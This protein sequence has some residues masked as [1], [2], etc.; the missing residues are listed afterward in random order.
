M[1]EKSSAYGEKQFGLHE[2]KFVSMDGLTVVDLPNS[3]TLAFE[4]RVISAE[5]PGDDAIQALQ[6][7]PIAADWELEHGGIPLA[8][9]ALVTGRTLSVDGVS[10]NESATLAGSLGPFPYFQIFGKVLDESTGDLHCKLGKAKL[11]EAPKGKF[12]YGKFVVLSMKGTA[13]KDAGGNVY[14]FA[15]HETA[16][17]LD[18]PSSGS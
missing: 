9:Y 4:E 11:T 12:E 3:Q 13:L 10:P 5:M 14:E 17:A 7:V 8:A 18:L 2:V 1:A 15:A 6:T 16:E